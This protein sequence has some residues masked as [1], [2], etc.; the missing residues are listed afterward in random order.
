MTPCGTSLRS[1]ELVEVLSEVEILAT[2]DENGEL[3]NLPFMPEMLKYC[4][5][6]FRVSKRADKTC[7]RVEKTGNRRMRNTVHLE[8]LRCNGAS[9]DG[10]QAACT[11]FWKEAWLRRVNEASHHL[12]QVVKIATSQSA[13]AQPAGALRSLLEQNTRSGV[14]AAR[15]K[16]QSTEMSRATEPLSKWDIAQH[17]RDLRSGNATA[18][19]IL[20]TAITAMFSAAQR[21]PGTWRLIESVRGPFCVPRF[22]GKQ[23]KSPR[24]SLDLQPGEWVEV[25]SLEEIEATLTRENK[26]RGLSFDVEMVRFCGGKYRVLA[27]VQKIID[28]ATGE[29][30]NLP[31]DCIILE[32]V[33]CTAEYHGFCP[34]AIY[35][36]WREIWLRRVSPSPRTE[37]ENP[38]D[39]ATQEMTAV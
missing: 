38:R 8:A 18:W 10:C 4:G 23:A 39:C 7:D 24:A 31:N 30:V 22:E 3:E 32:G 16:C 29:M 28:D 35:P 13:T 19:L 2:L 15:Y 5:G 37:A 17:W 20:K 36:Y 9:H 14:C 33:A 25:K 34:R 12:E 1:G 27:R 26:N 21:I 6:R 11:L